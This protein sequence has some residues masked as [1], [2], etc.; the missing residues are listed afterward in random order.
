MR[1]QTA[2]RVQADERVVEQSVKRV[3]YSITEREQTV[4]RIGLHDHRAQADGQTR[5]A[6]RL[7]GRADSQTRR[8]I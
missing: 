3:G 8:D 5:W 4:K 6:T 2:K 1:E 7:S